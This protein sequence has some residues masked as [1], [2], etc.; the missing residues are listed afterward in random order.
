VAINDQY[1]GEFLPGVT[2]GAEGP[3]RPP[4]SSGASGQPADSVSAEVTPA[5]GASQDRYPGAAG[6]VQPGQSETTAI[7]PGPAEDYTST[8]AGEGN[9]SHFPHPSGG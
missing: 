7:A 6:T 5:T 1:T 9:P 2:S 3:F 4:G 8:G